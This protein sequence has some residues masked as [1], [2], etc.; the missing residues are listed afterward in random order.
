[1]KAG[2]MM[3]VATPADI[4]QALR[5]SVVAIGNF[6]GVHGGHQAVLA[7]ARGQAAHIDAPLIMM[8]FEPH[9]RTFFMPH[10]PVFRL[11]PFEIKGAVASAIG[12]D[13]VVEPCAVVMGVRDGLWVR[14][15]PAEAGTYECNSDWLV[16]P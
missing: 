6:D 10:N 4:P 3:K 16:T 11:T 7:A 5:G 8:T 14:L 13:G 9:P 1:M 2:Q 12:V 15:L